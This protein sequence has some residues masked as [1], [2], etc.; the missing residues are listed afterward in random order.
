MD[1]SPSAFLIVP[2]MKEIALRAKEIRL[3]DIAY[4]IL[5]QC[6]SILCWSILFSPGGMPLG[7]SA[8]A[9][10]WNWPRAVVTVVC[11]VLFQA[12]VVGALGSRFSEKPIWGVLAA[13]ASGAITLFFIAAASV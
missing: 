3:V 8:P 5:F 6:L 4:T 12:G 2:W 11:G 7:A 10:L 9:I 13:L 1:V